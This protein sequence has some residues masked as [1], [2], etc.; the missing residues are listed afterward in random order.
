MQWS[1]FPTLFQYWALLM[2][3]NKSCELWVT[4]NKILTNIMKVTKVKTQY[5]FHPKFYKKQEWWHTSVI[6]VLRR[7]SQENRKFDGSLNLKG[8]PCLKNKTFY[9]KS[10]WIQTNAYVFTYLFLFFCQHNHNAFSPILI[11]VKKPQTYLSIYNWPLK[12]V[13]LIIYSLP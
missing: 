4:Q 7:L 1:Y 9:R 2:Y 5:L 6:L 3:L 8:R 12:L 10:L 11:H 13:L